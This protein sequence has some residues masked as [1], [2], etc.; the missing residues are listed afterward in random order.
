MKIMCNIFPIAMVEWE[1]VNP[2]PLPMPSLY[3]N[4]Y[5]R[6]LYPQDIHDRLS[7]DICLCIDG[8]AQLCYNIQHG[9]MDCTII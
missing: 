5:I 1:L 9:T 4:S 8:Y 2:E 7:K 6:H 3:Y